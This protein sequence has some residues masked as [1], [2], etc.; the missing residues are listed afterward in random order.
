MET[1]RE[2]ERRELRSGKGTERATGK[3]RLRAGPSVA[4]DTTEQKDE[5]KCGEEMNM[6]R[7]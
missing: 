7:R 5:E 6:S 2:V 3:V 4:H 1:G